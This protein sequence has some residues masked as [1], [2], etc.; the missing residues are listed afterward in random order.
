MNFKI[1]GA[2][3][4]LM[5]LIA[6]ATMADVPQK[7][8]GPGGYA[9]VFVAIPTISAYGLWKQSLWGTVLA[10]L[11]FLPQCISYVSPSLSLSFAAPLSINITFTTSGGSTLSYNIFAIAMAT[12]MALLF[13]KKLNLPPIRASEHDE[14]TC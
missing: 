8:L 10:F 3:L 12:Y 9:I 6:V 2:I 11:F 4:F 13:R 14:T 5:A 1:S 7:L